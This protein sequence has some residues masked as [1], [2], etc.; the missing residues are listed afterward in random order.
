V[1]EAH[2]GQDAAIAGAPAGKLGLVQIYDW[3]FTLRRIKLEC[4]PPEGGEGCPVKVTVRTTDAYRLP[5]SAPVA[6]RIL[7]ARTSYVLEANRDHATPPALD[8]TPKGI[9]LFDR[10]G[11][12]I[13]ATVRVTIRHDEPIVR[14]FKLTLKT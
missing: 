13:K 2:H 3:H 9:A 4:P 7:L 10:W 6:K 14:D 11:P 5:D 1:A 12:Y 8:L